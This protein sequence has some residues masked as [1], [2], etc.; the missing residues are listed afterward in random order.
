MCVCM[1]ICVG[2]KVW[3]VLRKFTRRFLYNRRQTY[4]WREMVD[5]RVLGSEFFECRSEET[6]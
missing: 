6:F 1:D 5:V 3:V 2:H 4:G